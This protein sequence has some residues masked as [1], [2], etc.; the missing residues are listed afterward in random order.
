MKVRN[1]TSSKGNSIPNQFV[2]TEEGRGAKMNKEKLHCPQCGQ[3][4]KILLFLGIFPEFVVCGK[5]KTAY[6]ITKDNKKGYCLK[7]IAKVI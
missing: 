6:T 2:I 4:L 1:M 7:A 5:C 3:E